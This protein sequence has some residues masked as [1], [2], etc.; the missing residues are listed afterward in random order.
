MLVTQGAERGSTG[1]REMSRRQALSD[2]K[3]AH[4]A[5]VAD[6]AAAIADA[7][8]RGAL[9]PGVDVRE[10]IGAGRLVAGREVD[11]RDDGFLV[12]RL[13][14]PRLTLVALVPIIT[15]ADE[16]ADDDVAVAV[17]ATRSWDDEQAATVS[18]TSRADARPTRW[19]RIPASC[20]IG[21]RAL[22]QQRSLDGPASQP[23]AV[24]SAVCG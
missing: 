20:R 2:G 14:P 24:R 16:D 21:A 9:L 13:G 8:E 19:R 11:G 17:L 15:D 12:T 23:M 6:P 1:S 5:I 7:V 10:A 22:T 18:K 3:S 4:P